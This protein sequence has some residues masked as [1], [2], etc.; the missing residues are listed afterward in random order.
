MLG[1]MLLSENADNQNSVYNVKAERQIRIFCFRIWIIILKFYKVL[2]A[3]FGSHKKLKFIQ[4][5]FK[6]SMI[7]FY[8]ISFDMNDI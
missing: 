4:A 3:S 8:F 7:T 1:Q 6:F 2:I 5:L